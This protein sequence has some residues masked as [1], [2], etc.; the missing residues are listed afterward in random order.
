MAVTKNEMLEFAS[1]MHAGY[2]Y[3]FGYNALEKPYDENP[4]IYCAYAYPT[5][6]FITGI[7][8]HY[9]NDNVKIGILKNMQQAQNIFDE[10][11]PHVF[12]G[13]QLH[14]C[15]SNIGYG[16]REYNKIRMSGIY[17]IRNAYVPEFLKLP[18]KFFMSNDLEKEI[19]LALDISAKNKGF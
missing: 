14:K 4:I 8:L 13:R 11:I 18:S 7:N 6:N 10:D 12:N 5:S 1:D 2:F 16:L 3:T 17:R 15:Y 19:Q 9:F